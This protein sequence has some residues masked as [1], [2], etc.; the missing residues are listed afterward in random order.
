MLD[1]DN[2]LRLHWSILVIDD[3]RLNRLVIK[4]TLSEYG[5]SIDEAPDGEKGLEMLKKKKYD[6][7]LVDI[8]MPHLD[9][10]GFI[11][12]FKPLT[13]EN[14]IPIILMTGLDDLNSKIMGLTIG[15][16]DF[17]LKPLNTRELIA[18]V[19][20]LLR[21]KKTHDELY[22]KNRL[23][24]TELKVARKIQQFVV[25]LSFPEIKNPSIACRYL[26]IEQIGG[27]FF[28]VFQL[29]DN[30]F[31]FLIADVTGHGI[32]AALV[33][34]M[35]TMMFRF[36][37][38]YH[39]QPAALFSVINSRVKSILLDG[40]YITAFYLI[41]NADQQ[42]LTFSNAGHTRALFYRKDQSKIMA[43][44]T[45]GFFLG[46]SDL[47]SHEEKTIRVNK[48]DRLFLYTDGIAELKN[49]SGEDFGEKGL[50]RILKEKYDLAAGN[51]CDELLDQLNHHAPLD[52]RSDD[53]AFM[54]IDF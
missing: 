32:P 41:Y 14:F 17:L 9:G 45:Q 8:V 11:E 27:D 49:T 51:F 23:I 36:H 26:P 20:S 52:S 19:L 5:M 47:S 4:R 50:A 37:A 21:L 43:L 28:D 54:C 44:D 30:S 42:T 12:A 15:A 46:I 13:A 38:P 10:F 7:V 2:I 53:I 6:L 18:R 3:S 40:Q 33:M 22:E 35:S 25:P 24:E 48:G 31:G 16:D 29:E 34:S 39:D 1:N